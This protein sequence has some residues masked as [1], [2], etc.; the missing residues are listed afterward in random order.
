MRPQ[1]V[2]DFYKECLKILNQSHIPFLVGG[3]F[4]VNVYLGLNRLT[5]DLDIF[6]RAGDYP[7]ILKIFSGHGYKTTVPDER[8]LAKVSKGQF[9]LDIIFGSA[10][11]A[12]AMTD[13]WLRS[14]Q[15]AKIF[16]LPVRLLPPTELFWSKAFIQDRN[17]YDGND[18]AHL[19]LIKHKDIDWRKLLSYMDQFWEVLLVHIL[20]FRFIYPSERELI[21]RWLMNELIGRLQDQFKVP[22]SKLKVCRGRH[23]SN[24]DF[25]VDINEWG[26]EDITGWQHAREK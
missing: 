21:P 14:S 12:V 9:Y 10:N 18:I 17:R 5:K 26:F 24:N 7:K 23:F 15:T 4:A 20:T 16:G 11:A 2:G 22:V 3:T 25:A 6:C 1:K 19:I 8:W 13:V